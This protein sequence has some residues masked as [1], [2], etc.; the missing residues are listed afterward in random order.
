M[1]LVY[2]LIIVF[3]GL[4][5]IVLEVIVIPGSSIIGIIGFSTTVGGIYLA[6]N[7][8]G[9]G[10]GNGVL[11]G[12]ILISG[13][14]LYLAIKYKAWKRFSVNAEITGKSTSNISDGLAVG[15]EGI[16]TSTLRPYG[17][18]EFNSNT[19]EVVSL[20]Q[21][22]ETNVPIRIVKIEQEKV[23]VEPIK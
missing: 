13:L 6:Y 9:Y 21:L 10:I 19:V 3:I 17:K 18:G 4:G 8:H 2:I 20:G 22:I 7:Y 15:L 16:S 12:S 23:F 1:E 11:T 14:S 5:L